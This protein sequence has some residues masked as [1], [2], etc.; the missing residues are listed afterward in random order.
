MLDPMRYDACTRPPTRLRARRVMGLYLPG[1]CRP[2]APT[3]RVNLD[4]DHVQLWLL[5]P[6]QARDASLLEQ[7]LA[8]LSPAEQ[9]QQARFHFARDRHRYLM[10][11]AG[12]RT[13]LSRYAPQAPEYWEFAADSHGRPRLINACSELEDLSFNISH[14][15]SVILIGVTAGNELGVDVEGLRGGAAPFEI[16]RNCFTPEECELIDTTPESERGEMFFRIWTLKESYIKARG[17]GL[18]LPLDRFGFRM[19]RA[20]ALQFSATPTL[21][22]DATRWH[23]AQFRIAPDHVASLCVSRRDGRAPAFGAST[24]VPLGEIGPWECDWLAT[25]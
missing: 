23:F 9:A 21:D 18:S 3:T 4:P 7:C 25:N 16:A 8:L 13:V 22:D 1:H 6:E 20:G 24:I 12:I 17:L 14:T 10:T 19:P 11:R 15:S 5:F 2:L